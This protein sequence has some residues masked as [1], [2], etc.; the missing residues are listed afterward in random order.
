MRWEKN[1]IRLLQS[2]QQRSDHVVKEW[3]QRSSS[4]NVVGRRS[5]KLRLYLTVTVSHWR[6]RLQTTWSSGRL[7]IRE[8]CTWSRPLRFSVDA[9]VCH[10]IPHLS[11]YTQVTYTMHTMPKYLNSVTG[12]WMEMPRQ[13]ILLSPADFASLCRLSKSNMTSIVMGWD[14]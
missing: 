2:L 1:E 14:F 9:N 6:R 3:L 13:I 12:V 8:F 4:F 10:P 11:A 7:S 5:W